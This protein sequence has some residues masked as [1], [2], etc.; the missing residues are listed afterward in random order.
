MNLYLESIFIGFYCALISLC[1]IPFFKHKNGIIL[2]V[3]FIIGFFKHYIA[4]YLGIHNYYCNYGAQCMKLHLSST[5]P[6]EQI[7]SSAPRMVSR[8]EFLLWDSFYEGCFFL[9]IG[10]LITYLYGLHPLTHQPHLLYTTMMFFVWGFFIHL[11]S[12]WSGT[13]AFFCRERCKETS[14]NL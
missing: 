12:E 14:A 11:F 4:Y 8:P 10:W 1:V 7:Q 6:P 2:I 9:S 13:H 3:F 5:T